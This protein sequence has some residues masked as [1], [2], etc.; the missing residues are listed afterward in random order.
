MV[1]AEAR[2]VPARIAD[3]SAGKAGAAEAERCA[4]GTAGEHGAA[5]DSACRADRSARAELWR[6]GDETRRDC[7]P[8]DAEPEHGD[9][10]E[11]DRERVLDRR[12]LAAARQGRGE[13]SEERRA[14]ADDHGEHQHLDSVR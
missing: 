10:R 2:E 8:E 5:D 9:G 1:V 13:L 6:A 7:R 4:G 11:H 3:E 14:D 12:L